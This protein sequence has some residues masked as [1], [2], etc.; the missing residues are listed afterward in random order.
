M[1]KKTI[2]LKTSTQMITSTAFNIFASSN[3][4]F[5]NRFKFFACMLYIYEKKKQNKTKEYYLIEKVSKPE[6]K[7]RKCYHLIE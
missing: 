2:T 3:K 1:K 5:V 6:L 7:T 4:N